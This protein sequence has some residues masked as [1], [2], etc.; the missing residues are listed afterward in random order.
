MQN[1]SF[2]K[3]YL[4]KTES[5]TLMVGWILLLHSYIIAL[6]QETEVHTKHLCAHR[7]F[8]VTVYDE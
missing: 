3:M 7:F 6:L 2:A 4:D 1:Y 5:P 8:F